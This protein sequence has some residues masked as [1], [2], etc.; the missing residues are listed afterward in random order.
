[1]ILTCVVCGKKIKKGSQS[2][3]G[4]GKDIACSEECFHQKFWIKA[5]KTGI[6][7]NGICYQIGNENERG[8]RGLD[9][10]PY[11]IQLDNGDIYIILLIY[12]I[13][14]RF[15]KNTTMAITLDL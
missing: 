13:M 5:L 2:Y 6:V 4:Y 1:M 7:I 15:R 11:R 3:Y 12:G 10:R 9:G 14:A 8:F